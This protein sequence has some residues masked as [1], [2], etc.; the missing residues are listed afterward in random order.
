MD[1]KKTFIF[2]ILLLATLEG[3][4]GTPIPQDGFKSLNDALDA[5]KVACEEYSKM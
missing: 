1:Q 2:V 4:K 5:L 3:I